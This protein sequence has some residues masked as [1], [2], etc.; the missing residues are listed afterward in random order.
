MIKPFFRASNLAAT[1]LV[2]TLGLS[3][4]GGGN[5]AGSS[6]DSAGWA[7]VTALKTNDTA[8]G[9]GATAVGGSVL[10][11]NYT[12]WLYDQKAAD[13]RGAKFESTVGGKPF[14]FTLGVTSVIQGWQLGILGMKA[15]GKRTLIIPASM[16]YGTAGAGNVIP[17]NAALVFDVELLT[18]K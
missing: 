17:P 3:A 5:D 13:L 9:T 12:G 10:T 4:C 6:T 1:V 2:A 18:V 16:A 15:G 11:V 7:S 8:V 14:G